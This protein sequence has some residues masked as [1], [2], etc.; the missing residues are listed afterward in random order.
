MLTVLAAS[1][2]SASHLA[3][4]SAAGQPFPWDDESEWTQRGFLFRSSNGFIVERDSGFGA[5]RDRYAVVVYEY[6]RDV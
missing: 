5:E 4:S 3:A 2:V 6:T 1:M